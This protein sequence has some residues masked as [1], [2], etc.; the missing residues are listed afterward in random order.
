MTFNTDDN[1]SLA[2]NTYMCP[3]ACAAWRQ[4]AEPLDK[5]YT[6]ITDVS[7][8]PFIR[9]QRKASFKERLVA[10][11][12]CEPRTWGLCTT[13]TAAVVTAIDTWPMTRRHFTQTHSLSHNTITQSGLR[14]NA[15]VRV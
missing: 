15:M 12:R 13:D 5:K 6:S 7:R 9:G 1:K 4:L 14:K 8:A 3:A 2:C 11:T 10:C